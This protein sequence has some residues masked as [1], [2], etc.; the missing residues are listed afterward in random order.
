M[1]IIWRLWCSP[2]VTLLGQLAIR[3]NSPQPGL[4]RWNMHKA[5]VNPPH[6]DHLFMI[7]TPAPRSRWPYFYEITHR[8]LPQVLRLHQI[9]SRDHYQRDPTLKPAFSRLEQGWNLFRYIPSP[10]LLHR[11]LHDAKGR[12]LPKMMARRKWFSSFV[13]ISESWPPCDLCKNIMG[14]EIDILPSFS[15]PPL[16]PLNHV[17]PKFCR[18][19]FFAFTTVVHL[20][21]WF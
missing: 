14:M 8:A 17:N 3:Q 18:V 13:M 12:W 15:H 20:S 19:R 1:K 4:W 21:W 5:R 7:S 6:I 9:G 10:S 16:R 2:G 11:W